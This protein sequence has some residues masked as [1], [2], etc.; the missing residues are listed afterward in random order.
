MYRC[1]C[2]LHPGSTD[3]KENT[4]GKHPDMVR[5]EATSRPL[6][7]FTLRT[8]E[9]IHWVFSHTGICLPRSSAYLQFFFFFFFLHKAKPVQTFL[10]IIAFLGLLVWESGVKKFAEKLNP[11]KLKLYIYRQR[12]SVRVTFYT[13]SFTKGSKQIMHTFTALDQPVLWVYFHISACK[14]VCAAGICAFLWTC[15]HCNQRVYSQSFY[16]QDP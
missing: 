3:V 6:P 14:H 15:T 4:A 16:C 5:P 12:H 11:F 8:G 2:H 10:Y 9:Y 13:R 7:Y 1:C